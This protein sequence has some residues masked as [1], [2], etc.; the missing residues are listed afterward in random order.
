MSKT[1][2][3]TPPPKPA[4]ISNV[5]ELLRAGKALG[6]PNTPPAPF[7]PYAVIPDGF[8]LTPLPLRP[9]N[10]LPDHIRQAVRLEDSESFI[11]YVKAFRIHTTRVFAAAVKLQNVSPNNAGGA[12]FTALLD[13]HEGQTEQKAARVAHVVEYPVPLSLEFS[14]WLASSGKGLAQMDFVQFIEN[15]CM[16]VVKPTSAD[17]MELALNF[18]AKTSVTFQSKVDRVSGGRSLIFQEDVAAGQSGNI[19]Q[20][21]VPDG[22]TLRIPVFEGG[23]PYEFQARLEYR[24]QSGRL[25]ITYH[26]QRPHDVFRAAWKDLRAE[27]AT[28][29][30]LEILTGSADLPAK[31]APQVT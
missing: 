12:K 2:E 30:E 28:A 15:N 7:A 24:P 3:P 10:P 23:K 25:T 8:T 22:L 29:L 5:E 26:L 31:E 9:L 21:K 11:T 17:L 19:G 4:P 13:Y 14:I 1:T 16:D 20:M 27:I 6:T 18:E